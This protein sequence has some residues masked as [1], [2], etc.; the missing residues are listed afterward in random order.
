[1]KAAL[2]LSGNNTYKLA[3][4]RTDK[5]QKN[6]ENHIKQL[7][8]I[9]E[10][11]NAFFN[12]QQFYKQFKEEKSIRDHPFVYKIVSENDKKVILQIINLTH[13][14][15]NLKIN[16]EI[17]K[18]IKVGSYWKQGKEIHQYAPQ[19]SCIIEMTKQE[20]KEMVHDVTND[21][22]EINKLG[23]QKNVE[24]IK[25]KLENE[26]EAK[27]SYDYIDYLKKK[28]LIFY[29]K[30]EKDLDNK[31]KQQEEQY[32]DSQIIIK[33]HKPDEV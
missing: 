12:S 18:K 7:G 3:K 22:I 6:M 32:E 9:P 10:N 31:I 14:S 8:I 25:I 4:I 24:K 5:I 1:M 28:T 29:K 16:N 26:W 13:S 21:P 33:K 27:Q 17:V 23:G 2:S 19:A 11:K 15:N 30:Y 20:Y